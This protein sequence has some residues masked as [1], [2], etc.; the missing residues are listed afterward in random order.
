MII[1]VIQNSVIQIFWRFA[2]L[3]VGQY[4]RYWTFP[5]RCC[6]QL[7]LHWWT[8]NQRIKVDHATQMIT[9]IYLD[10]QTVVR[11]TF[12]LVSFTN[13]YLVLRDFLTFVFYLSVLSVLSKHSEQILF[14][15]SKNCNFLRLQTSNFS[16]LVWE[17]YVSGKL[18]SIYWYV[19]VKTTNFWSLYLQQIQDVSSFEFL[20]KE[21][22]KAY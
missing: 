16:I 22:L 4:L 21:F 20:K 6:L 14:Y 2:E 5:L 15:I 17:K 10:V 13:A 12:N 1:Y 8:P 9:E 19:T 11:E 18:H 3:T 7:I